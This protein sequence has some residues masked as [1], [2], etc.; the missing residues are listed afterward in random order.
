[1][2]FQVL[3]GEVCQVTQAET[4]L[5]TLPSQVNLVPSNCAVAGVSSGV[6]GDGA[7]EGAEGG[8]VLRRDRIDVLRGAQ[9]AGAG[10]VLR[11][12]RGAARDVLADVARETSRP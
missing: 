4:S 8:A 10:H 1:M 11:H 5:V 3:T 7:A 2:S 6:V 12:D 9:A